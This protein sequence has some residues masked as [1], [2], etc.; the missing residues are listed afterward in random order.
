MYDKEAG[1]KKKPTERPV[2]LNRRK[3]SK[4]PALITLYIRTAEKSRTSR[5]A[6]AK[7][8]VCAPF[9]LL[10]QSIIFRRKTPTAKGCITWHS[11]AG[12][13]AGRRPAATGCVPA[14]HNEEPC[15]VGMWITPATVCETC[16]SIPEPISVIHHFHGVLLRLKGGKKHAMGAKDHPRR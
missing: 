2:D 5:A 10:V 8:G 6:R 11:S 9:L 16:F 4:T 14:P 12:S 1:K 13:G 15:T 3:E 7:K